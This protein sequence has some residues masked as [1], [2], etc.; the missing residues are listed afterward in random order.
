LIGQ[1]GQVGLPLEQVDGGRL[2]WRCGVRQGD[3]PLWQNRTGIARR[4]D[5]LAPKIG[6]S[7]PLRFW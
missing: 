5:P 7:N 1:R 3:A 2:S 4:V 6:L